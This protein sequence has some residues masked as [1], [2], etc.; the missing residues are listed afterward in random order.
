MW[1]P[2]KKA[3][4]WENTLTTTAAS[5]NGSWAGSEVRHFGG[6]LL[7]VVVG[8]QKKMVKKIQKK[9]ANNAVAVAQKGACI[10]LESWPRNANFNCNLCKCN[11]GL[12]LSQSV[13]QTF[14]QL[15]SFFFFFLLAG[16]R[17]MSE[18][19]GQKGCANPVQRNAC[20]RTYDSSKRQRNH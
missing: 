9:N 2:Q 14:C 16:F 15:D 5:G 18:H 17:L 20:G 8:E 1:Q 11:A 10:E 3:G 19:P 7:D 6:H 4:K 12:S 13:S